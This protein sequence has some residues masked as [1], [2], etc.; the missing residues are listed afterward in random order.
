MKAVE[1]IVIPEYKTDN[2][3]VEKLIKDSN[4]L[5]QELLDKPVSRGG[6]GGVTGGNGGRGGDGIVIITCW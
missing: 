4:K 6:G 5:L 2:K 1:S 3:A